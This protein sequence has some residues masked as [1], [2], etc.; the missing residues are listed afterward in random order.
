MDDGP[1]PR[2][3]R[4]DLTHSGLWRVCCIEG[5]DPSPQHTRTH[6]LPRERVGG[7]GGRGAGSARD[8][9]ELEWGGW[10]PARTVVHRLRS[11]QVGDLP[12]TR[13]PQTLHSHAHTPSHT[14]TMKHP[15]T[16]AR[17]RNPRPKRSPRAA[18]TPPGEVEASVGAG[19]GWGWG[20]G[21]RR[22]G[23]G[24]LATG[25]CAIAMGTGHPGAGPAGGGE[26]WD[27]SVLAPDP[28]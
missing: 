6:T 11:L 28:P 18:P 9:K 1:P 26:L 14:D 5:T 2:R 8:T 17:A 21:R 22:R 13:I 3:A 12:N 16:H 24:C 27:C 15:K 25:V 10:V 4:G 7:G 19:G 23:E 20:S